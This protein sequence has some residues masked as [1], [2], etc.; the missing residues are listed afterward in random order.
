MH[1]LT[2]QSKIKNVA[3]N[4]KSQYFKNG[5][6]K[7][8]KDGSDV[9]YGRLLELKDSATEEDIAS[10]IGNHS[11]TSIRCDDY[12]EDSEIVV[13]FDEDY[14]CPQCLRAALAACE[15]VSSGTPA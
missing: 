13:V 7:P 1:I 2:K 9:I 8:C 14:I 6:W 12:G 5:T 15:A 3:K 10:I 11:W 4:W